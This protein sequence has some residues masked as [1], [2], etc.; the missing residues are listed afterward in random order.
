MLRP[1]HTLAGLLRC[2]QIIELVKRIHKILKTI[3]PTLKYI[4]ALAFISR[5]SEET[6]C[7]CFLLILES[8]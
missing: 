4:G 8:L 1:L 5:Q 3:A 2:R 7:R 6:V